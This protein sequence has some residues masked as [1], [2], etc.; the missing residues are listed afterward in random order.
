[1]IGI[2]QALYQ[3]LNFAD[4]ARVTLDSWLSW[5]PIRRDT[6]AC[7]SSI[8]YSLYQTQNLWYVT[9]DFRR[10]DQLGSYY[11]FRV[12]DSGD[13]KS[14]SRFWVEGPVGFTDR[15]CPVTYKRECDLGSRW[16]RFCKYFMSVYT[17]GAD[18]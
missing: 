16:R 9:S 14:G 17:I 5:H 4:H 11:A 7:S 1:M 6:F 2:I 10:I 8:L 3:P 18:G 13:A 12:N 15:M